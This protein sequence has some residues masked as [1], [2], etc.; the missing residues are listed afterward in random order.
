MSS[1]GLALFIFFPQTVFPNLVEKTKQEYV[2]PKLAKCNIIITCF[3]LC[4]SLGAHDIFVVVIK[5]LGTN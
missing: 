5:I 1:S 3:D 4:M 2:W